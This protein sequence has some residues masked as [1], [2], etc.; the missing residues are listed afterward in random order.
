MKLQYRFCAGEYNLTQGGGGERNKKSKIREENSK[1]I[2]KRRDNKG[3]E[4]KKWKEKGRE[5]KKKG[6]NKGKNRKGKLKHTFCYGEEN[7]AKNFKG[8]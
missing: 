2:R 5:R 8:R 3:G 6:K 1:P 4:E 7:S